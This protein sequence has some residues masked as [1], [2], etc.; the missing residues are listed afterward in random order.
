M[1]KLEIAIAAGAAGV[2]CAYV[3][4]CV[5]LLQQNGGAF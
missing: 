5:R 1:T 3:A 2:I 4:Y